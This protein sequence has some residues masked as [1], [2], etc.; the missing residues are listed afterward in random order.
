MVVA[1]VSVPSC[2]KLDVNQFELLKQKKA[3]NSYEIASDLTS[4][5]LYW[6]EISYYS[7]PN[8]ILE[9]DITLVR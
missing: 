7:G 5:T 4:Y 6:T 1:V 3:F 2:Y 8:D 9:T